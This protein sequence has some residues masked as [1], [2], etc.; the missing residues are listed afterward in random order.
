MRSSDRGGPDRGVRGL[1]RGGPY[2]HGQPRLIPHA[3]TTRRPEGGGPRRFPPDGGV[4]HRRSRLLGHLQGLLPHDAV[5]AEVGDVVV[6]AQE[7]RGVHPA[8]RADDRAVVQPLLLAVLAVVG[9]VPAGRGGRAVRAAET[10]R[11]LEHSGKEW[12]RL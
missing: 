11:G 4:G 8:V 5:A 12:Q 6:E 3:R 10:R 9:L 1:G 7:A 2:G